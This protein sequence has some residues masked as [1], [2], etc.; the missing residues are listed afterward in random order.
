MI[1]QGK[2]DLHCHTKASDNTL[3]VREVI[4]SAKIAGISHL[5]ITDH[6]TTLGLAEAIT[7]GEQQGIHIIPGIEISAYDY[8]RN[9]RAH[10]LGYYI[11]QGHPAI[12]EICNPIVEQRHQASMQMV[13]QLIEAG[14]NL[15]WEQVQQYAKG[16]SAVYKQHIMNALMDNGYCSEILGELHKKLFSRSGEGDQPGIAYIPLQYVD[17]ATAIKAIREAGGI[18]VLAHPGQLNN[19]EAIAEWVEI[20]LEGIEVF[21][22]SHN[23]AGEVE[24]AK[25]YA[26]TYNLVMTGGSDFH[27]GY[28]NMAYPLGSI[29]AGL[30][31]LQALIDRRAERASV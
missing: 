29:D 27:G 28:G 8:N 30:A 14:Y 7:L 5:A 6:D 22:P 31:N 3:T 18:P 9:R 23:K 21:H 16:G 1:T 20:G 2:V 10:I 4:E 17:A 13:K 26:Q 15:T 19:Y 24:K 12:T 11:M 25:A